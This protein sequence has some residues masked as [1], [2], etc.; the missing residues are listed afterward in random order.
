[1]KKLTFL[2]LFMFMFVIT[3]INAQDEGI[4][5]RFTAN[6]TCSFAELD[7]IFIE[8]LSQGGTKVLYYPDTVL[9]LI[10]TNIGIIEG[11]FGNLYVSQNYPNPFTGETSIDI[12][13][14]QRDLFTL[15]VYDITGRR[16]TTKELKLEQGMHHFTFFACDKQAYILTVNSKNFS[17]KQVMIQSGKGS[18]SSPTI[19]YRGESIPD[20]SQQASSGDDFV[21]EPGDEL[22]F[23][24]YVSGDYEVITDSPDSDQDYFFDIAAEVPQQP[25]DILGETTV[26]P[27]ETGLIYEVEEIQ[28]VTYH[29]NVPQGWEITDGEGTHSIIVDAGTESGEISV[30]AENDCGISPASV[31]MVEVEEPT[32]YYNLTLSV[33]PAESGSVEGEG[34]Y[35]EGEQVTITATSFAGFKFENWTDDQGDEVSSNGVHTFFMPAMDLHYTANFVESTDGQYG[36][37]VT[38]IDGNEYLTVY[39]GELEWMAE[40]LR[41]STYLDGTPIPSGLSDS[42]WTDATQG[43]SAIFPPDQV[44]GIDTEEGVLEAYGKLYNWWAVEDSRGLCPAGWRVPTHQDWD[45]LKWHLVDNYDDIMSSN[46]GNALKDCRQV[47]S[48]MGGDCDTSEHPRWNSHPNQFGTDKYNFSALPAGGRSH[49]TGAFSFLGTHAHFWTATEEEDNAILHQMGYNSGAIFNNDVDK[50]LGLSMR[51]VRDTLQIPHDL[52]LVA[53]PEEGGTVTG[54]GEYYFGDEVSV[55]ATANEDYEFENW[56]NEADEVVSTDADYT[57][58]MPD[59]DLA[60]TANFTFVQSDPDGVTDIDGNEYPVVEIDG[61][62]WLA[63]N[64]RTTRYQDGSD[65]ITGLSDSDWADATDGAYA[66]YPHD[67]LPG[68]DSDQ[69][70][71]DAYG[72]LYNWYAID[73]SRGLCPD[74]W[75]V[76]TNDEWTSF[77]NYLIDN[78]EYTSSNVANA[79]KDCRQVNSPLGGDCETSDHPRWNQHFSHHGTDAFDFS[80]LPAGV[81]AANNGAFSGVGSFG[82]FWTATPE[83]D[84]AWMRSFNHNGGTIVSNNMDKNFGMGVRCILDADD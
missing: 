59:N 13:V 45:D 30:V 6:H 26:E 72:K 41:V 44:P 18:S 75:R 34:E 35:V 39:I 8:N 7:S 65:I 51:C 57:F 84:N 29:W 32:V 19:E 64:L 48:P 62:W 52:I 58:Y 3:N 11:S 5:L 14:P 15:D 20:K 79:L 76:P 40:N 78:Y 60:L 1:M 12:G 67:G 42:E 83:G 71:T 55:M 21:F 27:N 4:T 80:V 10:I 23:T 2:F 56:T 77:V 43:A 28:G 73:D 63:A 31:L 69:E 70:M 17:Q 47:N 46:V 66:I 37:G 54:D 82:A 53:S 25:S 24:G 16:L 81:R 9:S 33:D 74:D 38:D 61:Q 49:L 68:I 50:R 36:E 22:R